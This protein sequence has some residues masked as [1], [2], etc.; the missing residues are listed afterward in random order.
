MRAFGLER[1][2]Q[3]DKLISYALINGDSKKI[4]MHIEE[5]QGAVIFE[6]TAKKRYKNIKYVSFR[7][8]Y[9]KDKFFKE[10]CIMFKNGSDEVDLIRIACAIFSYEALLFLQK[11]GFFD[12]LENFKELMCILDLHFGD[13]HTSRTNR[14]Y[15]ILLNATNEALEY[16]KS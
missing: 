4:I 2:I 5:W 13:F 9:A 7:N 12:N 1:I 14:S 16:A 15:Q 8:K 11:K 3:D 10:F 6:N